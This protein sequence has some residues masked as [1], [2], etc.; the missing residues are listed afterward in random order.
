MSIGNRVF[1]KREL[2]SKEIIKE[3]SEIPAANVA[4]TMGR[5]CALNTRVKLVS[6]TQNTIMCGPALT[7]KVRG[8]DNL[9]IHKALNEAQEGDVIIV[10]NEG[11][12]NR[13]LI[14]EIMATFGN[15][16]KKI[17]GFV[18]DGPIR[19]IDTISKMNL[20]VY[21]TGSTPAGPYK[22]G[23]GE[24]NVPI[25]CG[26]ISVNPGDI[27]LGD[28]DGVIVIPKE[29]AE[30]TL[31]KAKTVQSLDASKVEAAANGTAKRGW[32]DEFLAKID[33]EIIDDVYKN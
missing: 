14:G 32:V 5:L 31:Q 27:I 18:F 21:A 6:S 16:C 22:E 26:D 28:A 7:V 29:A 2:P 13:A 33:C 4:D 23:P 17:A 20:H 24:M 15:E 11:G 10:S 8:G 30:V 9:M 12:T 25:A 1:L 3:F 19:D